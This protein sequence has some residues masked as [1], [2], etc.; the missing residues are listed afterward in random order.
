MYSN[1]NM[2]VPRAVS[3]PIIHLKAS[4]YRYIH[5]RCTCTCSTKYN[6]HFYI[7]TLIVTAKSKK[8]MIIRFSML[9][10]VKYTDCYATIR[11]YI[12]IIYSYLCVLRVGKLFVCFVCSTLFK[13]IQYITYFK[14]FATDKGLLVYNWKVNW[15]DTLIAI[16]TTSP[17]VLVATFVHSLV[18]L[19]I[20]THQFSLAHIRI[21][22]PSPHLLFVLGLLGAFY[23]LHSCIS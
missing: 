4:R 19:R 23:T 2:N 3:S 5:I 21:S 12:A 6:T 22:I 16:R 14:F 1:I 13:S 11:A 18:R 17:S 8:C 7:P 9:A 10:R 20:K 15:E